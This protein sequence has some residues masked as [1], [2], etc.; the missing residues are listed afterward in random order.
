MS[1]AR[2]ASNVFLTTPV[3]LRSQPE[4][5][6]M[7]KPIYTPALQVIL[8][9]PKAPCIIGLRLGL[10]LSLAFLSFSWGLQFTIHVWNEIVDGRG[11]LDS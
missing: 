4:T 9:P 2:N 5:L 8:Y 7:Q 6:G 1:S 10:G 11:G 3:M